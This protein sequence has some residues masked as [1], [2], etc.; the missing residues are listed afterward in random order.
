[1]AKDRV[2]NLSPEQKAAAEARL[3]RYREQA[4]G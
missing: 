3:Q 1:M 2:R 4:K